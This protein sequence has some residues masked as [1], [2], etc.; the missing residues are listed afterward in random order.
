MTEGRFCL[1]TFDHVKAV[2][3][4]NA[5][6]A[7]QYGLKDMK[8][9]YP[10]KR[11]PVL[12]QLVPLGHDGALSPLLLMKAGADLYTVTISVE[13]HTGQGMRLSVFSAIV[14]LTLDSLSQLLHRKS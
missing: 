2:A 8:P 10:A 7:K 3:K 4:M 14:A 6:I 9:F 13:P 5:K 1:K 12:P 11:Q